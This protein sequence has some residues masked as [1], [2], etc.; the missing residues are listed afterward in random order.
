MKPTTLANLS[1][2]KKEKRKFATITAYDASFA[3]LFAEQG[4]NVILIGD[5]LGM[6][7]QGHDS[8]LPV[9][10][11]DIS[12]HTRSVRT[13]APLAFLVADMPFMSYAT[14]EQSFEN[15]AALMRAGANMVKIEG[16]DW[17]CDTVKMLTERAVPVCGHLGLTPQ[18]VNVLGGYKVQ[19]RSDDA[20]Q[21][22]LN[23]AIAL[24]KAGMQLLVLECIP[25]ELAKR[26]TDALEI[27][28]IGIGAG[29]MT[30]GQILVMHDALGITAKPPK[31][32][33]DFLKETGNIRDAI[34][35]Y[36]EQVESGAYPDQ[37][38]S[39]N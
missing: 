26:V 18:S 3:H 31:F 1:Q 24:E 20:A 14:P 7:V 5:S 30:D 15:A 28:V 10:V 32:A 33:K 34:R 36:I 23:D 21:K 4:I 25:V 39:F 2:L 8:T 17:L 11:E 38:H 16:G 29:N 9:T 27:P 37:A 6:T 13:G 35:L 12:Y 22:L 19:G